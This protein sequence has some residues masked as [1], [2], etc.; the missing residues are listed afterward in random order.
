MTQVPGHKDGVVQEI[1][2]DFAILSLLFLGLLLGF[3]F[4]ASAARPLLSPTHFG[5]GVLRHLFNVN[6]A[7]GILP[8]GDFVCSEK[9]GPMRAEM[10]AKCYMLRGQRAVSIARPQLVS[11]KG[12]ELVT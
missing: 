10:K 6:G 7:I 5:L 11:S 3:G 2:E 12:R 1:L 8:D 9:R 4:G